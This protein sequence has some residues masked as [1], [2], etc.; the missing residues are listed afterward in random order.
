MFSN[1]FKKV[2][3]IFSPIIVSC[4]NI[5]DL[6]VVKRDRRDKNILLIS[7]YPPKKTIPLI[8]GFHGYEL[9]YSQKDFYRLRNWD[10]KAADNLRIELDEGYL[11]IGYTPRGATAAVI[12]PKEKLILFE[13]K[14][15][16]WRKIPAVS[17]YMRFPPAEIG[18][19]FSGALTENYEDREQFLNASQVVQNKGINTCSS[20]TGGNDWKAIIP[21]PSIYV[22]DADIFQEGGSLWI[23]ENNKGDK[24]PYSYR[25]S[26]LPSFRDNKIRPAQAKENFNLIWSSF[27]RIYPSFVN[28]KIDWLA[29]K[30]EYESRA[31]QAATVGEFLR[32][33]REMLSKLKD[34]HIWIDTPEGTRSTYDWYDP[35]V[36]YHNYNYQALRKYMESIEQIGETILLARTSD[37]LTYIAFTSWGPSVQKDIEEL[38]KYLPDIL[39]SRGEIIDVRVNTGGSE[40]LALIVA[41]CF[42]DKPV[43]Y[44]RSRFR[45]GPR[46]TDLTEPEDRI[47]EPDKD[48]IYYSKATIVLIGPQC[49]S[50]NESFVSAMNEIPQV[51]LIGDRTAGSSG[52]PTFVELNLPAKIS[53]SIP[54]W[55]DLLP[56]GTPLE[57][58]GI[59]PDVVVEASKKDFTGD[60]DPVLE[61]AINLMRSA[62]WN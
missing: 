23:V 20:R 7:R 14:F 26:S 5:K 27:D 22:V 12:L 60:N 11:L 40:P 54:Q 46:H 59:K 17:I 15:I 18:N 32:I 41:A 49:A 42:T 37:N 9:S 3:S 16:G 47:L 39:N 19:I 30:E 25:T 36:N 29:L 56:D 33:I 61:Q 38:K 52:N 35:N 43:V 10:W 48:G 24:S 45:N 31:S 4:A 13:K 51:T 50:S 34:T 53:I 28:K 21:G 2:I 57:K 44:A 6:Q 62:E 58:E 8:D 1:W 55:I